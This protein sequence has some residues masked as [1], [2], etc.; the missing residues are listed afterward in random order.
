M[1][2]QEDDQ[3]GCEDGVSSYDVHRDVFREHDELIDV[4]FDAGFYLRHFDFFFFQ[5]EDGIRDIGVTGVQTCALP[6]CSRPRGRSWSS[7]D[8][9]GASP[10]PA[11]RR[12]AWPRSGR[13]PCAPWW[14]SSCSAPTTCRRG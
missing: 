13:S 7:S 6:I 8:P 1:L 9:T 3:A 2:P 10:P 12:C 11:T 14:P 4:D 5:A